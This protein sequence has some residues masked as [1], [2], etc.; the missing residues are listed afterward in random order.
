MD[1][2][3][4]CQKF[5]DGVLDGIVFLSMVGVI[6]ILVI[7]IIILVPVF[8]YPFAMLFLKINPICLYYSLCWSPLQT[9]S[10]W[11]ILFIILPLLICGFLSCL[12]F[13]RTKPQPIEP[14]LKV[15]V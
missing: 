14:T 8:M 3:N 15:E 13:K 7:L 12:G 11:T 2:V 10:L 4:R 1:S 9:M 5:I 6:V